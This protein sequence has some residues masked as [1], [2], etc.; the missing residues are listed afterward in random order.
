M[1]IP[2]VSGNDHLEGLDLSE[3]PFYSAPSLIEFLIQLIRSLPLGIFPVSRIDPDV[4]LYTPVP[5]IAADDMRF[6]GRIRGDDPRLLISARNLEGFHRWF[7]EERIVGVRW[8]NYSGYG[9]TVLINQSTEFVPVPLLVAIVP[10]ISP[11]FAG[12][13][14]VSVMQ[15]ARSSF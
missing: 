14:L 12:I 4:A 15:W 8:S 13:S 5:V 9:A 7:I 1:L 10:D 11:I 2:F 6:V 3:K